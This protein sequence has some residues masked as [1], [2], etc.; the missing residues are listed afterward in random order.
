MLRTVLLLLCLFHPAL[1]F[2][3]S[4]LLGKEA[5]D[6]G[7]YQTALREW[8]DKA[9]EGHP[10]SQWGLGR[11]YLEGRGVPKD[12]KTATNWLT[13]SAKS[14]E[15]FAQSDLAFMY[16]SGDSGLPQNYKQAM[17]WFLKV[18]ENPRVDSGHPLFFYKSVAMYSLGRMIQRGNGVESNRILAQM[19]FILAAS[20]GVTDAKFWRDRNAKSMSTSQINVSQYAAKICS[21]D[22]FVGCMD[23]P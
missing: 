1:V 3:D 21:D 18:I 7:D 9:E 20:F 14:G 15:V 11:L 22:H 17:Y 12:V 16:R 6:R 23:Q 19:W 10:T 13:L 4:Y 8:K 5:Y 2:G